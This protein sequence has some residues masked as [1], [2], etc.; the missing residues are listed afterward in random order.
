M[1]EPRPSVDARTVTVR[2]PIAIRRRGGRKLVLAPDGAD[3]TAAPVARHVDN[4][5]VKAIARAFRWREMLEDGTHATIAEIAGAEKINESYVG[6]VLRLTLLAPDIVEAIVD[7][8][9]PAD[10]TLAVLIKPFAV[11]WTEQRRMNSCRQS[12]ASVSG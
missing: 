8:R 11:E 9:Q 12:D 6:R 7:G 5:M 1:T 4:A 10:V 2:V 3:V